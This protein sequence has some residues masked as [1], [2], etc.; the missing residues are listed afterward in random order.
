MVLQPNFWQKRREQYD[1]LNQLWLETWHD[2]D[3]KGRIIGVQTQM[4]I[5]DLLLGLQLSIKFLSMHTDGNFNDAFF[6]LCNCFSKHNNINLPTLPLKR[7]APKRYKIG[8]EEGSHSATVE[9]HYCQAYLRY[10][11]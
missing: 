3:V 9:D 1:T 7:K 10:W 11:I 4:T 6:S 5:F 2:P 8:T